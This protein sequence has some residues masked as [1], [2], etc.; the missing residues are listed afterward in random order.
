[1]EREEAGLGAGGLPRR[2]RCG[3]EAVSRKSPDGDREQA[4]AKATR[5]S[6]ARG[7]RSEVVRTESASPRGWVNPRRLLSEDF[8]EQS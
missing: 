6:R 8:L 5:K 3:R 4:G 2:R 1:M 7:P